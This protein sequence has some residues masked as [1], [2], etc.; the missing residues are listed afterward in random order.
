MTKFYPWAARADSKTCHD[1]ASGGGCGGGGEDSGLTAPSTESE[2][3]LL[4]A[5]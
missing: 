4:G 1:S 2:T 5:M 3:A